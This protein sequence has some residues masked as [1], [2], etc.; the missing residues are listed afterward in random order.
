[1]VKDI[2]AVPYSSEIPFVAATM[3]F[4]TESLHLGFSMLITNYVS[5]LCGSASC[6]ELLYRGVNCSYTVVNRELDVLDPSQRN[7]DN[8]AGTRSG[9]DAFAPP[10][11]AGPRGNVGELPWMH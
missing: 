6:V 3:Q 2:L 4:S 5:D 11:S 10:M 9:C 1:M 8:K 7:L